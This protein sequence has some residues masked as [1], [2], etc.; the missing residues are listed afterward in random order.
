MKLIKTILYLIFL[1]PLT[2]ATAVTSFAALLLI[3]TFTLGDG[4]DD[5]Q[6][7]DYIQSEEFMEMRLENSSCSE[8]EKKLNPS[9]C[10]GINSAARASAGA[11]VFIFLLAFPSIFLIPFLLYYLKPAKRRIVDYIWSS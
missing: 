4:W 6:S 1:V 7:S 11:V 5:M 9:E 2:I 3:Y 8:E 10:A